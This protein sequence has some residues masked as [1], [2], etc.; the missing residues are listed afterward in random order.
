[1]SRKR[2]SPAGGTVSPFLLLRDASIGYPQGPTVVRATTLAVSPGEV[3]HLVGANGSGKST[4]LGTA[5]GLIPPVAGEAAVGFPRAG[6]REHQNL[7]GYCPAQMGKPPNVWLHT[8]LRLLAHGYGLEHTRITQFWE[9]LG[10]SS[11]GRLKLSQLSSGNVKK[12]LFTSCFVQPRRL[13]LADEPFEEVDSS[14]RSAMQEIIGE[15]RDEGAAIVLTS[16]SGVGT[17]PVTR[18]L[19]IADATLVDM[20][21]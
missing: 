1:M 10:G 13:Y 14:G 8:W 3:I 4:L 17:I 15:R 18:R 12:L 5:Y 2:P 19:E 16:H 9:R 7:V 20:G 21:A 6:T 11:D